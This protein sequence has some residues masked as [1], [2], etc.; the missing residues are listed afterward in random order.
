[1]AYPEGT[2]DTWP[3][4][5]K[6]LK[7]FVF[8]HFFDHGYFSNASAIVALTK[9]EAESIRQM[10]LRNRLEIIPNGIEVSDYAE[11]ESRDALERRFP[12]LIGRLWVLFIGR[13]HPKKGLAQLVLAFAQVIQHYHEALLV[14][15]GPDEREHRRE[16][17]VLVQQHGLSN[18]VLFTGPVLGKEKVGFLQNA[19]IFVL[20]SHSEGF[21]MAV[22]EALACGVPVVLTKGCH[23][24]EVAEAGA[25]IEVDIDPCQI[26]IAISSLL[27]DDTARR[28][29][30]RNGRKLVCERFTWE[31]VA[32]ETAALCEELC[33]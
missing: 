33:H 28:Q 15:A 18:H 30:G 12:K 11:G 5:Q 17:E 27:S 8:W 32:R 23:V 14:I 7:K 13:I 10:G 25:G 6:R 29:M 24:P 26:A 19:D 21:P 2:F 9:S 1:L 22:L 3:L 4:R 31:R 20:P 16:I